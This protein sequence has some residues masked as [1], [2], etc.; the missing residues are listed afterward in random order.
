MREETKNLI[1]TARNIID[2]SED[3]IFDNYQ[4]SYTLFKAEIEDIKE[5]FAL[6]EN[7]IDTIPDES[8]DRVKENINTIIENIEDIQRTYDSKN[9]GTYTTNTEVEDVNAYL[10][11]L[12]TIPEETTTEVLP[13]EFV[14]PY[15]DNVI[16]EVT[17]PPVENI[18]QPINEIQPITQTPIEPIVQTPEP[19]QPQVVMPTGSINTDLINNTLNTIQQMTNEP[20]QVEQFQ[21]MTA[22]NINQGV[23]VNPQDVAFNSSPQNEIN[24]AELDNLFNN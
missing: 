1:Q 12:E 21:D 13:N 8:L 2:E 16:N 22:N 9:L 5:N 20:V 24:V 23:P 19:I 15:V 3:F 14:Q 10:D 4:S 6:I 7:S 11:N 18:V 17:P